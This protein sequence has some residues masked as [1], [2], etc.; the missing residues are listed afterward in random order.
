VLRCA[1]V[2]LILLG[3]SAAAQAPAERKPSDRVLEKAGDVGPHKL[4][5][6]PPPTTCDPAEAAELRA[7]L[8]RESHKAH[9]WNVSWAAIFGGAAIG[10]L[11][12]G[13]A[14]P[15][16]KL[17]TGLYVSAGKAAIG[18]GGRLILPLRIPIPPPNSDVCADIEALRTA[19]KVAAKREKGNFYL[20][21]VAGILVN[22]GG[23]LIVWKYGTGGQAL[24]SI[25]I[26]YPVGLLSNYLAP[27]NSWHYFRE[28][29]WTIT[30]QPQA[31][32]QSPGAWLLTVGGEL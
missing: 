15:F 7:H 22:G 4:A 28:H 25:A 18:A 29:D 16:P 11:A 14:N 19:V 12:V 8:E 6:P 10:S 1:L 20:N 3:R 23:A 31:Q 27:R 13:L 5:Q 2:L 17:Q 21:H 24:L 9:V 26:G 30:V 32:P